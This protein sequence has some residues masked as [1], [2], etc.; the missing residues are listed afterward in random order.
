MVIIAA[1]AAVV[2]AAP[3]KS[4]D[5]PSAEPAKYNSDDQVRQLLIITN[6]CVVNDDA[7]FQPLMPY[8]FEWAV[9]DKPSNNDYGH[10]ENS[11]GKLVSGSY[12]VL[13]PDSRTQVV[14]YTVNENGYVAEVKYEGEAKYPEAQA[15]YS[16]PVASSPV[17]YNQPEAS[18]AAP[19]IEE[20]VATTVQETVAA[21]PVVAAPVEEAVAA[22]PAVQ[23][24]VAAYPIIAAAAPVEEAVAAQVEGEVVAAP[25]AAEVAAPSADQE[26]A[27]AYHAYSAVEVAAAPVIQATTPA[28]AVAIAVSV[29]EEAI[30]AP[31]EEEAIIAPVEEEV[32][33]APVEEIVVVPEAEEVAPA[34]VEVVA[35]YPTY[36]VVE[37]VVVQV[38]EDPLAYPVEELVTE[39]SSGVD[40]VTETSAVLVFDEPLA[41]AEEIVTESVVESVTVAPV[42]EIVEPLALYVAPANSYY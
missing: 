15:A 42:L 7:I 29:E 23:E 26:A 35:P 34:P 22:P 9:L 27:V 16:A 41:I 11:D 36:S 2:C 10:Q 19:V 6:K 32:P 14:T 28:Y 31:V 8:S 39:I 25:A 24:A 3:Y 37:E 4:D 18:N 5:Q 30:A 33:T 38:A 40:E 13:L 1:L 17:S 12:R 21:Y 20:T